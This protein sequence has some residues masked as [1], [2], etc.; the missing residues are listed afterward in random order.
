M[1]S[2]FVIQVFL[3]IHGFTIRSLPLRR[4]QIGGETLD[5]WVPNR[6]AVECVRAA[7]SNLVTFRHM[8]RHAVQ[9]WRQVQ[10]VNNVFSVN[11]HISMKKAKF[12]Y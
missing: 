6:G 10:F 9:M 7:V 5:Q 4:F 8:W 1:V 2:L 3:T 12:L 11:Y